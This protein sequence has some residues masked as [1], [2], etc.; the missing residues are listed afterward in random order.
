MRVYYDTEFV[1]RGPEHPLVLV[2]IG[3]VAEDG[4]ELY[5]V[6]GEFDQDLVRS[7]PWLSE[8]VWPH[9]PLRDGPEGTVLDADHPHV[10]TRREIAR[11]VHEFL[12]A[13]PEPQLWAWYGSYDHVLLCQLWGTM[14]AVPREVPVITFDLKQEAV[15]L[16]DPQLPPQPSGLHHALADARHLRLR[17]RWLAERS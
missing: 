11:M 17:A 8:N 16:G 1:E 9:L 7:H 15:R 3:M 2:S 6:S 5:A 12:R 4:R 13:T 14:K 10:R